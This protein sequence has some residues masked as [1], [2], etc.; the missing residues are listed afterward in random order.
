MK[1]NENELDLLRAAVEHAFDAVLITTP[2]LEK[3]GPIILYVN[4]AFTAMTG[5]SAEEVIGKSPRILQGPKT[6]PAVLSQ[7]K[8]EL[9]CGGPFVGETVN[10][11]K[12]GSE[13]I[14]EWRIA[15]I[16]NEAGQ[17]THWV[18]IQRD[19]TTHRRMEEK[20]REEDRYLR[21]LLALQD[22]DRQLIGYEIHDGLVQDVTAAQIFLQ[23]AKHA[24]RDGSA[25]A[26]QAIEDALQQLEHGIREARRLIDE[27]RVVVSED[28]GMEQAIQE[29]ASRA[30]ERGTI[31]IRVD[32]ASGD[33]RLPV[34]M[35]LT[36]M[37]IVQEAITNAQRHGKASRIDVLLQCMD[38]HGLRIEVL[39]NGIGF[40]PA[41]VPEDRFGL[42]GVIKRAELFGGQAQ[43]F[44][45]TGEG[46]RIVVDLPVP[47]GS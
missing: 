34:P 6:D 47:C 14:L 11:R 46:T 36:V 41:A 12:D 25:D 2:E 17:T 27:L 24:L 39:D 16:R 23:V 30:K 8:R 32:D 35:Q 9:T 3:P 42:E 44:S 33:I 1:I 7:L 26:I 38:S 15:G 10:Y 31:E 20:L 19:N 40:D 13:F 22:R 29:I 5:Y 21:R 18:A 4:P 28:T 45:A 43:I 37:R